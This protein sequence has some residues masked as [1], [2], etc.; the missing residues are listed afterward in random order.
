[1]DTKYENHKTREIL[2]IP[3][4]ITIQDYTCTKK[5]IYKKQFV[6]DSK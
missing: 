1:M 4:Q 5:D 3:G 2:S 6:I